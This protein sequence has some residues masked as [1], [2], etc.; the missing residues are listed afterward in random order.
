MCRFIKVSRSSYYEWL[1]NPGSNKKRED[2]EL[3]EMIKPIFQ[4]GRNT[5]GSRRIKKQLALVNVIASRRRIIRL[6]D[7]QN[8]A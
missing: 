5:Y 6:A 1:N 7:M 2:N 3:I 8:Q 4:K